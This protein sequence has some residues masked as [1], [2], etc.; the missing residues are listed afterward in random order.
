M[1][2]QP[3]PAHV[4]LVKATGNERFELKLFAATVEAFLLVTNQNKVSERPAKKA[5]FLQSCLRNEM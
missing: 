5:C 3:F 1:R 2:P 4:L